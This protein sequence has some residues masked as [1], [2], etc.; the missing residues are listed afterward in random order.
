MLFATRSPRYRISLPVIYP[1]AAFA[2]MLAL[3]SRRRAR[4]YAARRFQE[5]ARLNDRML[6]DIGLSRD[7][8]LSLAYTEDASPTA[9]E[10]HLSVK[11]RI[12]TESLGL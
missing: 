9:I 3:V 5:L 7:A 10:P 8:L 2:W 12:Q 6:Q 1:V 4:N 11:R